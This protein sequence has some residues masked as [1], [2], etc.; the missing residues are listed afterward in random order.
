MSAY[1]VDRKHITYLIEAAAKYE[2]YVPKPVVDGI[3]PDRP[4][5]YVHKFTHKE[6]EALGQMLWDENVASLEGRYPDTKKTREYPGTAEAAEDVAYYVHPQKQTFHPDFDFDPAQVFAA[7]ACYEY[8][9]C[10]H[11]EWDTSEAH[12]FCYHLMKDVGRKLPGREEAA[13]G[14]PV[15]YSVRQAEKKAAKKSTIR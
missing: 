1:L 4:F 6:K 11:K 13:W 12:N 10:E 3:E 5:D 15:P 2:A 14:A 8:Q 7:I 9:S